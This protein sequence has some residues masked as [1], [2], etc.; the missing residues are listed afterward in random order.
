[1]KTELVNF[2]QFLFLHAFFWMNVIAYDIF[3][4]FRKVQTSG[5][6]HISGHGLQS[7]RKRFIRYSCYAIGMPLLI[8]AIT[9]LVEFVPHDWP[10]VK[11]DFGVKRCFF[12]DKNHESTFFLFYLP[13]LLIQVQMTRAL[14][15][16]TVAKK[17]KRLRQNKTVVKDSF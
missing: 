14:C 1:M 4:K 17:T 11:P 12:H 15:I 16:F 7:I 13:L 6:H 2:F 9:V 3:Q 5:I 10:Q 8:S